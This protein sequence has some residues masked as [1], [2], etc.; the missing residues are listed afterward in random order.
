[1]SNGSYEY[2]EAMSMPAI[3]KEVVKV[4]DN[5]VKF[6]LNE[7][8]APFLAD[9]GMDFASIQ[10]KEYADAMLKAGTPEVIDQEPVGTGPFQLVAYQK[11]AVIRYKA[12]PDYWAGKQPIDDLIFAITPM[13]RS[14][15]RR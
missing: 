7:P 1:M 13:P 6:V 11:D 5:T 12:F 10:S 4:D 14:A 8:N 2:F 3:L 15:P 9:L